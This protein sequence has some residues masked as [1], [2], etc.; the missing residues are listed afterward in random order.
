MAAAGG[1]AYGKAFVP[2]AGAVTAAGMYAYQGAWIIPFLMAAY[3]LLLLLRAYRTG[4]AALPLHRRRW[5]GLLWRAA[6]R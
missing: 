1:L 3:A 2:S 4:D 6:W 5:T